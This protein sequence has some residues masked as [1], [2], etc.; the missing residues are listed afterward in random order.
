LLETKENWSRASR[1]W[2]GPLS[3]DRSAFL[4][5]SPGRMW[6]SRQ[7]VGS[8]HRLPEVA[9]PMRERRRADGV[10]EREAG[11]HAPP[12]VVRQRRDAILL[13]HLRSRHL[14]VHPP[15]SDSSAIAGCRAFPTWRKPSAIR[16][17]MSW[18]EGAAAAG[19]G[20]SAKRRE[21][22]R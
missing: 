4:K 9:P 20:G 19:A 2:R 10:L 3:S 12:H 6:M 11:Q 13:I 17:R 16:E 8:A 15:P 5:L 1:R 22:T 21:R 14:I 7:D 18:T